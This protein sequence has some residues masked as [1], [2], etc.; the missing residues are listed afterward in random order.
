MPTM[1]RLFQYCFVNVMLQS[2]K[3]GDEEEEE[4]EKTTML[5]LVDNILASNSTHMLQKRV[6]KVFKE[7]F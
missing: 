5:D 1:N 7:I 2:E 6:K 4:I 3:H